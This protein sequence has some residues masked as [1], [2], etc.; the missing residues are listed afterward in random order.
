MHEIMVRDEGNVCDWRSDHGVSC[1]SNYYYERGYSFNRQPRGTT[2]DGVM[3]AAVDEKTAYRSMSYIF[4]ESSSNMRW[5]NQH[6]REL[7]KISDSRELL[8][9]SGIVYLYHGIK[10][11]N[12]KS[13]NT[14]LYGTLSDSPPN[15]IGIFFQKN[16]FKTASR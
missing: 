8:A 10:N 1:E 2:D 6:R 14:Y 9:I 12:F 4:F 5:W 7:T 16:W 3:A 13:I 15:L 11:N